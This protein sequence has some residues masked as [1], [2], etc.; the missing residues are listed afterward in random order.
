MQMSNLQFYITI[1]DGVA[2]IND[3]V[4]KFM[5]KQMDYVRI[6]KN[7]ARASLK[8]KNLYE[9]FG[10]LSAEEEQK[11]VDILTELKERYSECFIRTELRKLL[12]IDAPRD[13]THVDHI[14]SIENT[15]R[16]LHFRLR[17]VYDSR[18]KL[19]DSF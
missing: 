1:E 13:Y 10:P 15:D 17:S 16:N 2:S 8:K 14:I 3:A 12:Q 6:K 4:L 5:K 7:C 9:K 11:F 19:L 18:V